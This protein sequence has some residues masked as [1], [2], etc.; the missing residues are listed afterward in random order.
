MLKEFNRTRT[1]ITLLVVLSLFL[2]SIAFQFLVK[3]RHQ[4]VQ[5][6]EEMAQA[7]QNF[8]ET[9]LAL[10]TRLEPDLIL[11]VATENYLPTFLE[12][13]KV[14]MCSLCDRFW[15]STSVEVKRIRVIEYSPTLSRVR[16]E[17]SEHGYMIN[18]RNYE[19]I[20][21]H[22]VVRN[23]T[24][25]YLFRRQSSNSPWLLDDIQDYDSPN[26]INP[27]TVTLDDFLLFDWD[28]ME[29]EE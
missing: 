4:T 9:R 10:E 29:S 27:N 14:G 3:P 18:S 15:V 25:T 22:D 5:Y 12:I 26:Y 11:S 8:R 28:K 16:A 6:G 13:N 23:D 17:I 24:A 20:T 1:T 21:L 19:R 2:V 7:I